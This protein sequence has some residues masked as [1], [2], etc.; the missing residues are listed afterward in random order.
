MDVDSFIYELV[1][2]KNYKV[3]EKEFFYCQSQIPII[4]SARV[5]IHFEV[6]TKWYPEEFKY[7]SLTPQ[8]RIIIVGE[9][10]GAHHQSVHWMTAERTLVKGKF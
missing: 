1:F 10:I 2:Q 8:M 6:L 9:H 7:R 4:F 3:L 5:K